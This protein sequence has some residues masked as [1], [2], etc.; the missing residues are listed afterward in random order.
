MCVT[1]VGRLGVII[2]LLC[3]AQLA[4]SQANEVLVVAQF[5]KE[6]P[7]T[8]LP[9]GWRAHTFKKISRHSEYRL[10]KDANAVVLQAR[11]N[12]SA[13]ALAKEISV[14]PA[15]YPI[16]EWSWKVTNLLENA[17]LGRKRGDDHPARLYVTFDYDPKQVGIFQRLKYK[18]L[19]MIY[20]R[21]PPIGALNYVW[22]SKAPAGAM[23]PNPYTSRVVMVVLESGPEKVGRWVREQRN[24]Y[25][26]YKK[27]FGKDPTKVS[28]VAL[29]TDTDNT[30]ESA[31]TY[32]GDIFL[33]RASPR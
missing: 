31:T 30:G 27:A 2:G 3:Y 15:E 17:D 16:L 32:Y 1:Q 23:G 25:E 8:A 10:V 29:M 28:G 14:D 24:I 4:S 19:R 33:K 9:D 26:D 5:S 12:A 6:S 13:S 7:G 21:Y 11:S 20:G 18:I 22:S